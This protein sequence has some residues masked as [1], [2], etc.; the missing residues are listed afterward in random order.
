[1]KDRI[2]SKLLGVLLA[3]GVTAMFFSNTSASWAIPKDMLVIADSSLAINLEYDF[4]GSTQTATA[5]SLLHDGLMDWKIV[6]N[7]EHGVHEAAYRLATP[8]VGFK[9][10]KTSLGFREVDW[11]SQETAFRPALCE[12]LEISSDWKTYVWHL[13]KGV[14][15][16][17]GNELTSEDVRY[18]W[19]R[20][21]YMKGYA[22]YKNSA[23]SFYGIDQAKVLDKYSIQ[24]TLPE[25]NV[26]ILYNRAETGGITSITDSTELKKHA[27]K[28]DP[29]AAKWN[30]KNAAGFGPYKLVE[31]EPGNQMV[32]VTRDDYYREK[33]RF[34][35]IVIK[36]V[37]TSANRLA[38]VMG[39]AVDVARDLTPKEREQARAAKGCTVMSHPGS[40]MTAIIANHKIEPFDD[41]R[42]RQAMAY[43]VPYEDIMKTVYLGTATRL[44][45]P[46]A[47]IF[48][49]VTHYAFQFDLHYDK[50]KELLAEAGFP[51]GFKTTL[52]YDV[53]QPVSEHIAVLYRSAAEKAGVELVLEKIPSAQFL[54]KLTG[55]KDMPMFVNE[56]DMP[57]ELGVQFS[58]GLYHIKDAFG[59]FSDYYN[60]RVDEL[61]L[62]IKREED[63]DKKAQMEDEIQKIVVDD[64]SW[65][66]ISQQGWHIA[67]REDVKGLVMYGDNALRPQ[68]GWKE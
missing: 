14:K 4:S 1:M 46:V 19:E 54:E 62:N 41:L 59:N 56:R 44:G 37:P 49:G 18:T 38:L 50:A 25:P 3:V 20:N 33:P 61:W 60:P 66:F 26:Q 21:F 43:L 29:Y 63:P 31:W 36:D 52:Y 48:P 35:R 51:N 12:R 23:G 40:I 27:T 13:R 53:T 55:T 32:F 22:A 64:V 11:E 10:G 42:V 17:Y 28:K 2:R 9:P 39:G 30:L 8:G 7:K 6:Y 5:I 15:S 34:K 57:W 24:L 45:G 58:I 67:A 16:S 47:D 68:F 65:I